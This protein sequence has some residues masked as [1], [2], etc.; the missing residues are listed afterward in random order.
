MKVRLGARVAS[1][2]ELFWC[3]EQT[4]EV[5]ARSV[6]DLLSGD[7]QSDE[8]VYTSAVTRSERVSLVTGRQRIGVPERGREAKVTAAA[9]VCRKAVPAPC[10]AAQH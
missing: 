10:I 5:D 6:T 3:Q 1:V 8:L 2:V 7:R 9:Q 4:R